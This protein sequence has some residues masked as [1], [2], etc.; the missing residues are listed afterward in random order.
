MSN[1]KYGPK[2]V[3]LAESESL[4]SIERWRQSVLYLLRLNEDFRPFMKEGVVFGK[5]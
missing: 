3:P 1:L 2:V 4:G 5:K